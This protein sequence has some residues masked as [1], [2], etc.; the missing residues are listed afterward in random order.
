MN[1]PPQGKLGVIGIRREDDIKWERRAPITPQHVAQLLKD[2]PNLKFIVQ[3]SPKRI[4][5]DSEYTRAGAT[6]SEDLSECSTIFGVKKMD[7]KSLLPNKTYVFFSHVIKAQEYNMSRLDYIL[8]NKIRL[9][10]YER[11]INEEK[12]RLVDFGQFGG[13]AGAIDFFHGLGKYFLNLGYSTPFLNLSHAYSYQNLAKAK[14]IINDLAEALSNE[15]VPK[16]YAPF[17]FAIAGT[18]IF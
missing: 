13:N 6:I 9:I 16:S 18:G 17:I 11:I 7:S 15:G 10:D 2:H 8:Q 1:T 14:N 3:P 4:F 5:R 12:K